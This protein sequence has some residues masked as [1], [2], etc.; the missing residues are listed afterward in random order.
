MDVSIV[1]GVNFIFLS[2][3]IADFVLFDVSGDQDLNK[4]CFRDFLVN[5]LAGG[6]RA[7]RKTRQL[8]SGASQ[9]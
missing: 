4:N 9:L 6:L 3:S 5:C 1:R 2:Q 8:S 7:F